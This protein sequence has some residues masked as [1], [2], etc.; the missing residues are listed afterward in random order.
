MALQKQ[1]QLLFPLALLTF[2]SRF[3]CHSEPLFFF[4]FFFFLYFSV[5][6]LGTE[7]RRRRA[8]SNREIFG[9]EEVRQ[10]CLLTEIGG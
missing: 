8:S 3:P 4:S 5:L 10:G 7:L 1:L 9:E 6:V 2:G